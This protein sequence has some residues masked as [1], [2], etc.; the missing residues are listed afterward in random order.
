MDIRSVKLD[1]LRLP[2][3]KVG[4]IS[5]VVSVYIMPLDPTLKGESCPAPTGQP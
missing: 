2:A 5:E 4:L 3:L 1:Q